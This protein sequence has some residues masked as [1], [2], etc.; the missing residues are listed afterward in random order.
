M[1][2]VKIILIALF[3]LNNLQILK[4]IT[5]ENIAVVNIQGIDVSEKN[6]YAFTTKLRSE[7]FNLNVFNVM[8]REKMDAILE[9][10]QHSL[11]DCFSNECIIKIGQLLAVQYIVSGSVQS[12]KNI[13]IVDLRLIDVE[14]SQIVSN[15]NMNWEGSY[16]DLLTKFTS[17]VSNEL[18]A[19]YLTSKHISLTSG[20]GVLEEETGLLKFSL[21]QNDVFLFID[22]ISSGQQPYDEI[23][24]KLSQGEHTVKFSKE[25]FKD[26]EQIYNVISDKTI[27]VDVNI[28]P[29]GTVTSTESEIK[30]GVIILNTDP[31]NA[32]VTIDNILMGQT[33]F[34]KK[35]STGEHKIEVKKNLYHIASL[36]IEIEPGEFAKKD[37]KLQPNFGTLSVSSVPEDASVFINN[38]RREEKTPATFSQIQ[39]GLHKV[40]LQKEDYHDWIKDIIITDNQTLPIKAILNPTFGELE[41]ISVPEGADVYID[42]ESKGKTPL[43]LE[44]IYSREYTIRLEKE[45]YKHWETTA[46][47]EDAKTTKIDHILEENF[48]TLSI[49]SMPKGSKI[50]LDKKYVGNTPFTIEKV[51]KG[52][53]SIRINK[54]NHT[55][56]NKNVHISIGETKVIT[57]NLEPRIGTLLISSNPPNAL[58]Y[59]DGKYKGKTEIKIDNI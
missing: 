33:P 24:L 26:W 28:D 55:A 34:Q 5:K 16:T 57:D 41:L 15:I 30:Y 7:L 40:K 29:I 3:F 47:V 14:T 51:V 39:S 46:T 19:K 58:A 45:F 59:I 10:Q 56:I 2:K 27:P 8:E 13:F 35:I 52:Q 44:K 50:Y 12:L 37:I 21:S 31:E 4:A 22:G 53:H 18:A 32:E 49:L 54:G 42:N 17:Q 9:E 6:V 11:S 43:K 48:G 1:D 20:N 36:E 38:K 23:T 25:G